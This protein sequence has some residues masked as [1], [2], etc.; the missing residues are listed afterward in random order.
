M[1]WYLLCELENLAFW[2]GDSVYSLHEP[3][4]IV[5][6][7]CVSTLTTILFCFPPPL[8]LATL[9]G[10]WSNGSI[11]LGSAQGFCHKR[12]TAYASGASDR[13][14]T[15]LDATPAPRCNSIEIPQALPC[16]LDGFLRNVLE[17]LKKGTFGANRIN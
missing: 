9:S 3:V 6:S 5:V 8:S 17:S 4:L 7:L 14:V 11:T 15:A 2:F 12:G 16:C 10:K 1:S 13:V